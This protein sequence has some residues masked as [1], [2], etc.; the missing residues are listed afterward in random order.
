MNQ[1]EQL[2]ETLKK[3]QESE[4]N[5]LK[6]ISATEIRILEAQK[7]IAQVN[8]LQ[9]KI[10]EVSV[11]IS[12]LKSNRNKIDTALENVMI[13]LEDE[14]VEKLNANLNI[15]FLEE[16]KLKKDIDSRELELE[17]KRK[18]L[19]SVIALQHKIKQQEE[20]NSSLRRRYAAVGNQ[21]GNK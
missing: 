12:Q 21:L 16:D 2:Q 8:T 11:R 1:V 6:D 3:L 13:R 15:L 18:E 7:D 4:H 9:R 17:K 14:S 20:K 5:I 10:E 19:E